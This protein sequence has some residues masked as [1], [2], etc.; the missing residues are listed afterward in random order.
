MNLMRRVSISYNVSPS[1]LEHE[2]E[3]QLALGV[4]ENFHDSACLRD[5]IIQSLYAIFGPLLGYLFST[6]S[7]LLGIVFS[8]PPSCAV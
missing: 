6:Y 7:K 4:T 8:F 1:K 5:R 2:Q 3:I